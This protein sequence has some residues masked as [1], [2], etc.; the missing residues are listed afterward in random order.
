MGLLS[1]DKGPTL[2]L[3]AISY[4]LSEPVLLAVASPDTLSVCL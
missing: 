2:V 1:R 3:K 4:R